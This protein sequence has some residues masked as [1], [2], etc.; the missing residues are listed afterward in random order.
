[1]DEIILD[2]IDIFTSDVEELEPSPELLS[3]LKRK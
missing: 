1:M 3:Y 2:K